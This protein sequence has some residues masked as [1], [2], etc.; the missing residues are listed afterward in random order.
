[1][2]FETEREETRLIREIKYT[3]IQTNDY[4][5][6]DTVGMPPSINKMLSLTNS[7]LKT[8]VEGDVKSSS[9]KEEDKDKYRHFV[10]FMAKDERFMIPLDA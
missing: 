2:G 4:L 7:Y 1:M 10:S 3:G 8:D 6:F 9:I 5:T